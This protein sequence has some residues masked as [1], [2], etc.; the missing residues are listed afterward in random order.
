MVLPVCAIVCKGYSINGCPATDRNAFQ[1]PWGHRHVYTTSSGSTPMANLN[2][3]IETYECHYWENHY[4]KRPKKIFVGGEVVCLYA[5]DCEGIRSSQAG[6]PPAFT[7][8]TAKSQIRKRYM[9]LTEEILQENPNMCAYMAPPLDARHD[10]V[11]VEV[12]KLGKAAAQIGWGQPRSRITHLVFCTTSGVDMPGADYQLA[13]MLGL[14]PSVNRLMMYQQ[15]CFAGG[16]VLR[17]AKDLART[18]AGPG[19]WRGARGS[20]G[21]GARRRLW[22]GPD[23]EARRRRSEGDGAG[24]RRRKNLAASRRQNKKYRVCART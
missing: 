12:P 10:I 23:V 21:V 8:T 11:V 19:C 16:T 13:K 17:V 2:N 15:G 14:R 3:A 4:R 6:R 24:V 22:M 1:A 20:R 9:H 7:Q 5:N 18:T